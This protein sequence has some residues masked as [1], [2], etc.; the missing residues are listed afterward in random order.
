MLTNKSPLRINAKIPYALNFEVIIILRE[1]YAQRQTACRSSGI[2]S[3][4]VDLCCNVNILFF[5]LKVAL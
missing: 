3:T 5:C 4:V 2:G 1:A